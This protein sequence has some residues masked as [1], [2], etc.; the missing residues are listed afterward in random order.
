VYQSSHV[1]TESAEYTKSESAEYTKLLLW[2]ANRKPYPN[3]QMVP[4]SITFSD[5]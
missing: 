5:L 2:N 1:Y 4:Y 3:F